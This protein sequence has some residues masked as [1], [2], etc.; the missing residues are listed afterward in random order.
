[1]QGFTNG[2]GGTAQSE[3]WG[4]S[5]VST[6]RGGRRP[7]ATHDHDKTVQVRYAPAL[8]SKLP[9]LTSLI[10]SSAESQ[11]LPLPLT[12]L[13]LPTPSAGEGHASSPELGT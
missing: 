5:H 9:L 12:A 13:A 6:C 1:L 7:A 10:A 11:T 2:F 4:F 3:A 8:S